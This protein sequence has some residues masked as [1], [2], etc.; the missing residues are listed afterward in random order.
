MLGG[1][2]SYTDLG[3]ALLLP[4]QTLNIT[5]NGVFL[6]DGISTQGTESRTKV[7]RAAKPESLAITYESISGMNKQQMQK[8][9]AGIKLIYIYHNAIDAEGD[10]AS[11]EHKV[12]HATEEAFK[13]LS[14]LIRKIVNDI[15]IV[16]FFITADHGYI[17]RRTPLRESDKTPR[18]AGSDFPLKRRFA[19]SY[20]QSRVENTQVFSMQFMGLPDLTAIVPYGANCFKIQGAGS[21]YVHGGSALQ[22]VM[23]PL[24]KFKSG[25]NL[26]KQTSARKVQIALTS[27]TRKITSQIVYL[28]FQQSE[29]VG[30]KILPLHAR[31][32]LVDENGE[33]ISNENIVIADSESLEPAGRVF[34]EKFTLRNIK[35]DKRSNYYLVIID[36][37]EMIES[38]LERIPFT[39]DLVFGSGIF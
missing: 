14:G 8:T 20:G 31:V 4:H 23:V 11:T 22:E 34:R 19:L 16:N 37:D 12:F 1:I 3:M 17:Y 24:I 29:P 10:K 13:E 25:R 21:C 9:F 2:P 36:D 27:L 32:A 28:N 35:Y 38:E 30:D 15:G 7:L 39:V 6:V 33:R 5:E 18:V 26:S